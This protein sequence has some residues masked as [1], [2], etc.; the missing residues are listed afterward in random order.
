MFPDNK[1]LITGAVMG[2]YSFG[3]L[4]LNFLFVQ[5]T[6]PDEVSPIFLPNS[7]QTERYF[8]DNVSEQVPIT[9]CYV[10]VM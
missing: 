9:I 4:I 1:G 5:M 3:S 7:N 2:A 10:S 6:N 8:P